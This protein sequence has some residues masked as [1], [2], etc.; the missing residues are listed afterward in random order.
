MDDI[1]AVL[2][3]VATDKDGES[4]LTFVIPYTEL[5]KVL[6]VSI[7]TGE[8]LLLNIRPEGK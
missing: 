8:I 1:K 2:F 7:L 6:A 3:R 5:P 4:K